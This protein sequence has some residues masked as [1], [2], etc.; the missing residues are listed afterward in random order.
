[1]GTINIEKVILKAD[2]QYFF[3]DEP[4]PEFDYKENG[5]IG[6]FPPKT[7]V[8]FHQC[9]K[10]ALYDDMTGY[11][12]KIQLEESLPDQERYVVCYFKAEENSGVTLY[13]LVDYDITKSEIIVN[14]INQKYVEGAD[15]YLLK[16][17]KEV[18]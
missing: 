14:V 3:Y 11:I 4:E 17:L 1:M 5:A 7:E 2:G 12:D 9:N 18:A 10:S 6:I 13:Q 8:G 15:Y 16:D